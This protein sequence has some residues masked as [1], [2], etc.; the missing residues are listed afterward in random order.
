ME[1]NWVKIA[2]YTNELTSELAKVLLEQHG[3][4]VVLLNK[5]DSSFKFGKIE[6]LVQEGD[7]KNAQEIINEQNEKGIDEN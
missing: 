1:N 3:I 7:A 4:V 6:L 5:Q 2:T